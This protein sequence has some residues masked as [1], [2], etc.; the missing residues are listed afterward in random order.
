MKPSRLGRIAGAA[1]LGGLV[2][3]GAGPVRQAHAWDAGLTQAG[4][5]Q[6][7]AL[8][9]SLHRVLLHRLGRGLGAFE[10][11][12]LDDRRMG[13]P[14]FRALAARLAALDAA[15]GYRPRAAAK[16]RLQATA[17]QWLMAGSAITESSP[18][19]GRKPLDELMSSDDPLGLPALNTA[20]QTSVAGADPADR[21]VALAS[22]LLALG[23]LLATLENA[24]EPAHARGDRAA[25]KATTGLGLWDRISAFER[26][27]ADTRGRNG[28]PAPAARASV[29]SRPSLLAFFSAPDGEGLADRTKRWFFSEGTLPRDVQ[30]TPATTPREVADAARRSLALPRPTVGRLE[31][32]QPGVH[33]VVL[34]G[35]RILAYERRP[36][37][38]TFFL[39]DRVF[40]DIARALLPEVAAYATGLMEHVLRPHLTI[41][42][43]DGR[44]QIRAGGIEGGTVTG[45]LRVYAEDASGRRREIARKPLSG[46]SLEA[47]LAEVPVP[48]GTELVG[49]TLSGSGDAEPYVALGAVAVSPR[50]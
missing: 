36:D 22:A 2:F 15:Q 37:R 34:D 45:D 6:Q 47:S 50:P 7:A 43:D 13:A 12:V 32:R 25:N 35:R 17:L 41:A 3:V 48:T 4:L 9:S 14:A 23:R 27:V 29:V 21:D 19:R 44:A 11:L 42:L 18:V 39:D 16:G 1:A 46:A 5:T 40:E 31:L 26:F 8:A 33:H 20:L 49:A 30:V 28:V 10:P 38:V 24:G